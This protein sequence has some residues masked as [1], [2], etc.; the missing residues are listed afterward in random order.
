[1]DLSTSAPRCLEH[2][3]RESLTRKG[4]LA[5]SGAQS[6]LQT[7][8][9]PAVSWGV[10]WAGWST[11]RGVFAPGCLLTVLCIL[12]ASTVPEQACILP[13]RVMCLQTLQKTG[14]P[15]GTSAAQPCDSSRGD[16]PAVGPC[17]LPRTASPVHLCPSHPAAECLDL[18]LSPLEAAGPDSVWAKYLSSRRESGMWSVITLARGWWGTG[19]RAWSLGPV[20]PLPC[21]FG[22]SQLCLVLLFLCQFWLRW[23]NVSLQLLACAW[24]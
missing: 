19:L 7:S 13:A 8:A 10:T 4:M 16:R 21:A 11:Q 12:N 1:M 20:H 18:F 24:L 6:R 22:G 17:P 3:L 9:Y 5:M 2:S 23:P 15:V 14:S